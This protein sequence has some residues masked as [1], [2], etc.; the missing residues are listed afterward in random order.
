MSRG[1]PWSLLRLRPR[2]EATEEMYT[3]HAYCT[4]HEWTRGRGEEVRCPLKYFSDL[5]DNMTS[6]KSGCRKKPGKEDRLFGSSYFTKWQV[7]WHDV[8]QR[9]HPYKTEQLGDSFFNKIQSWSYAEDYSQGSNVVTGPRRDTL[10]STTDINCV[11][12]KVRE[13][14]LQ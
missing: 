9:R 4:W 11:F 12:Q 8:F 13:S 1:R 7:S 5:I 10:D 3:S 6:R 2:P 14:F